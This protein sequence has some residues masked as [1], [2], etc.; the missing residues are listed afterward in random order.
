M[1]CQHIRDGFTEK[2]R[3]LLA[4]MDDRKNGGV[5]SYKSVCISIRAREHEAAVSHMG[6][7]LRAYRKDGS[8]FVWT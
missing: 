3:L 1:G 7:K 5:W 8:Q 6:L 4:L 2:G